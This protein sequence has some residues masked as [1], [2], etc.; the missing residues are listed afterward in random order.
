[1]VQ[2]SRSSFPFEI[3]YN[4]QRPESSVVPPERFR[5]GLYNRQ[6]AGIYPS[7]GKSG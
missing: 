6:G 7:F 1:M 2:F 3:L 4:A 5:T